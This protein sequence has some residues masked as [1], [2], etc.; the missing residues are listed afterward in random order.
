[1]VANYSEGFDKP[2]KTVRKGNDF[3]SYKIK[4]T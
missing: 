3:L 1:M 2:R 4:A